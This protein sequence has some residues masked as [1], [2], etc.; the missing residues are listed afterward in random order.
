MIENT[1]GARNSAADHQEYPI[2]QH[3]LA[4]H[5]CTET[6]VAQR[7]KYLLAYSTAWHFLLHSCFAMI[8]SK[9]ICIVCI[10][11]LMCYMDYLSCLAVTFRYIHFLNLIEIPICL[12][13]ISLS[14]RSCQHPVFQLLLYGSSGPNIQIQWDICICFHETV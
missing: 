11:C 14:N 7:P 10:L 9:V 4:P 5:L 12:E 3:Q 2:S 6:E 8:F 13:Y 1:V